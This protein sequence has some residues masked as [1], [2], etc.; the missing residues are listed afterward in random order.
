MPQSSE[1]LPSYPTLRAHH[2]PEPGMTG[3]Y[4][5]MDGVDGQEDGAKY[6]CILHNVDIPRPGN[7]TGHSADGKYWNVSVTIVWPATSPTSPGE[8]R[9]KAGIFWKEGEF[10]GYV[11][12]GA[13][14]PPYPG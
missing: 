11:T 9:R 13:C 2:N 4:I 14:G 1:Y 3:V 5:Y 12:S 8:V 10:A 6:P 7:V